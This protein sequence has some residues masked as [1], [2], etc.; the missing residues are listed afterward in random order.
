MKTNQQA[1]DESKEQL[2]KIL[3][4]DPDQLFDSLK[5]YS[6]LY[7]KYILLQFPLADDLKDKMK[8]LFEKQYPRIKPYIQIWHVNWVFEAMDVV[9]NSLS[10][11]LVN[12]F[13]KVEKGENYK[14]GN[15][16]YDRLVELYTKPYEAR[17]AVIDYSQLQ[18]NA[19]Q[20]RIYEQ[21]IEEYYQDDLIAFAKMNQK[22]NE[23][24]DIVYRQVL[25]YFGTQIDMLTPEQWIHYNILVGMGFENYLEDCNE[26]NYFLIE[27]NMQEYT[28]LD[29]HHFIMKHYEN[30]AKNR[31]EEQ[32][33]QV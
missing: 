9:A 14:E 18:L 27:K 13:E 11:D 4:V 19:E 24:L 5:K 32:T 17:K 10:I 7:R 26:L 16:D 23:F 29:Y 30:L 21:I 6:E 15:Y 25:R 1:E 20:L 2:C 28:G 31:E 12:F 8:E 3:G 22:R 33:C